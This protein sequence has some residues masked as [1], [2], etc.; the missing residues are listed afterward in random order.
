MLSN[1]TSVYEFLGGIAIAFTGFKQFKGLFGIY[2]K[3]KFSGIRENIGKTLNDINEL[4][5]SVADIEEIIKDSE[6]IK[7]LLQALFYKIKKKIN[8]MELFINENK[9]RTEEEESFLLQKIFT[10]GSAS[11][12][13]FSLFFLILA[14]FESRNYFEKS[15]S[16]LYMTFPADVDKYIL[17]N[18]FSTLLLCFIIY[19]F[20]NL[21]KFVKRIS[22]KNTTIDIIYWNS[23]LVGFSTIITYFFHEY[24]Y[25]DCIIVLFTILCCSM[26]ILALLYRY[27]YYLSVK[28][29]LL[30][31]INSFFKY[32]INRQKKKIKL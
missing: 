12:V 24:R 3:N 9:H 11:S 2:F 5:K 4:K 31:G 19:P 23:L 20:I 16:F 17:T 6:K 32:S 25:Y 1:F 22:T 18:L 28:S 15:F 27:L 21:S 14:G 26:P 29:L 30:W 7:N 10:N 13:F 8:Y